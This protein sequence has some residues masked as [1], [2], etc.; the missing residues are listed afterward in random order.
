MDKD[1]IGI[2]SGIIWR[3]LNERGKLS[4]QELKQAT[5]LES[6]TIYAAVDYHWFKK[7]L[8]DAVDEELIKKNP[9]RGIRIVYDTNIMLKEILTPKEINTLAAFRY[10]GEHRE[11]QRAFIFCCFTGLRTAMCR[12]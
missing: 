9:C 8:A 7:V 12:N 11:V 1:L 6:E 2:W 5:G 4:V 10:D 3:T